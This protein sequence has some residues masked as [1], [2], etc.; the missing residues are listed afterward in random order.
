MPDHAPDFTARYRIRYFDG[1]ANHTQ[2]WR[3][4]GAGDGPELLAVATAWVAYAAALAPGLW[5]DYAILSASFAMKDSSIFLPTSTPDVAGVQAVTTRR[6]FH[7]AQA[8]SFVGRT[9]LG[10]RVIF[11]QYGYWKA[12]GEDDDAE[13][14]RWTVGEEAPIHDAWQALVDAGGGIVGNDGEQ[15]FWYPYANTGENDYWKGKVRNG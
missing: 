3:Y 5:E 12:V 14:F 7:K 8:L 4:P 9:A 1:M 13:D 2:T 15:V 10:K 6:K 11:Y